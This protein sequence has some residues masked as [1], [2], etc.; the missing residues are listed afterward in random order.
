MDQKEIAENFAK[1][2]HSVFQKADTTGA[3]PTLPQNCYSP[4]EI[5]EITFTPEK[6]KIALESLKVDSSPGPDQIPAVFLSKCCQSLCKPLSIVMNN[7]LNSG[8]FPEIW[9]KA[10][11][12]PIY[13]KGNKLL[14]E[15]YRPISLT[16]TIC[17]CL[18]K[19]V[20]RE[21]TS[22]FLENNII[23]ANQH[24][25]LPR[26]STTTNLLTRLQKWTLADD[27]HQPIDVLYL[28]FEKAFDKIPI[29]YLI[30]K[31]NHYGVR[32]KLI[33]LIENF[34]R[35]RSYQVRVG[36]E[37]SKDYEVHSGVP[38]GSVLG[39]LL[40]IIY[41]SDM[42]TGLK[43]NYSSF[44]DDTNLYC[45][46][47]LQTALLQE[48]L[49]TIKVWTMTWKMPLNDSKCTVLHIGNNN[50]NQAYFLG[51]TEI[52]SVL[53]Q[54]D[55]GVLVTGDLKWEQHITQIIK[56]ANTQIYL[57]KTAFRDH[58]CE[59]ILKLYKT[60]VRPKIEYAQC[61]WSPYYV[62]DIEALERVQRRI[63]KI[64]SQ[65]KDLPYENR[66][67]ELKLTTLRERRMRGD[68]IETY[69]I[70]SDYYHCSLDI[71]HPHQVGT[72]RGHNKKISKERCNKLLRR[73]FLTNRVVYS[74]NGLE[75][76]TV[77]SATVNQ[78]KNRLDNEMKSW[79]DVLIH[80]L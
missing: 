52:T 49:E 32:G 64:P 41:L 67:Q 78:F 25:F 30:Y 77:N 75:E 14:P 31:L 76:E 40:F 68:L 35:G 26:R 38:Q 6:V 10:V 34:L 5:N 33:R 56:K 19:V 7:I 72:L 70:I 65:L 60:F 9:K 58:S 55:L 21:M 22:F 80:Y 36:Q 66:L 51:K 27:N 18:K 69:K 48:D 2:F 74:W 17:K 50:P 71:F 57:I 45:N 43:T 37:L 28:D 46:P 63:T 73:N 3:S 62:K 16:S 61:I 54:R 8:D 12:I 53:Q 44:A 15:N 11:V 23:P 4:A 39:P 29:N 24:G 79:N 1:Q 42:Y 47:L 59:M 13:K 20:V